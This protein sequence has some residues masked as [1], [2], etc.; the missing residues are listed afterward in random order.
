MPNLVSCPSQFYSRP[1]S[2]APAF[3]GLIAGFAASP[4]L[5]GFR[6]G[7]TT[8]VTD[9]YTPADLPNGTVWAVAVH[10]TKQWVACVTSTH[11]YVY[12]FTYDGGFG[13]RESAID[14]TGSGLTDVCFSPDGRALFICGTS[15]GGKV[16][17]YN[18]DPDGSGVGATYAGSTFVTTAVSRMS[19]AADSTAMFYCG[20][21]VSNQVGLK[22]FNSNSG[23]GS[24]VAVGSPNTGGAIVY[25][26]SMSRKISGAHYL[27]LGH[28]KGFLMS[29][30]VDGAIAGWDYKLLGDRFVDDI[31]FKEGSSQFILAARQSGGRV[32][33]Y[34]INASSPFYTYQGQAGA[35]G[36]GRVIRYSPDENA[37]FLGT[38]ASPWVQAFQVTEA[39]TLLPLSFS[40]TTG[41]VVWGLDLF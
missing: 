38:S 5:R 25:N 6:W 26:V 27:V 11:L 4:Y 41:G 32:E 8:D 21:N 34:G 15:L 24:D 23:W 37:V 28:A 9:T 16:V 29:K 17:A 35:A 2:P 20:F 39:N 7:T 31:T 36:D 14:Y 3:S 33:L 19:F 10:P 13:T 30:F 1:P 40:G 18:F 12:R 22:Y